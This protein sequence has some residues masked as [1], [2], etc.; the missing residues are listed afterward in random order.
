MPEDKL[1][2]NLSTA[3]SKAMLIGWIKSLDGNYSIDIK[4]VRKHRS[5]EQNGFYFG[6]VIP[7]VRRGIEEAWGEKL[8]AW[9]VHCFLR[10]KFLSKPVMDKSTGELKGMYP[11][12]TA[13]LDVSE[14]SYF[15]EEIFKFSGEYLGLTDPPEAEATI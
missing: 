13:E 4:K 9:S 7:W 14:F 12:S 6:A 2:L 11:G 10:D 3:K 5:N 8:D 1:I 15:I